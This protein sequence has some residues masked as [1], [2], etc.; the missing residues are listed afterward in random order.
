MQTQ[1]EPIVVK[2]QSVSLCLVSLEADPN[3]TSTLWLLNLI[4]F[5]GIRCSQ[6]KTSWKI[7]ERLLHP[8]KWSATLCTNSTAESITLNT[9]AGT[10]IFFCSALSLSHPSFHKYKK[11][12][13]LLQQSQ[14][15][16][17]SLGE[18]WDIQREMILLLLTL[19]ICG[20]RLSHSER[21]S[22]TS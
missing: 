19:M 2:E 6:H 9:L 16:E 18:L 15:G 10:C 13:S 17:P 5:W 8:C 20:V 14:V 3:R 7:F 21:D 11:K 22:L 12:L 4:L 1:H